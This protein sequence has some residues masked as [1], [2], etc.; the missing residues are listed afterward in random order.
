[1]T[2]KEHPAPG[3]TRRDFIGG[4]LVGAGAALLHAPAPARAKGLGAEWTGYGGVGDYRFSNGNTASVVESAHAIRDHLYEGAPRN[5]IDV[6]EVYDAVIVGGGFSG[7]AAL[8]EFQKR[9]PDAKCLLLENHPIFGGFAKP[10]EFD[11]DG[12]RITGPQ[13]SINFMLPN[14]SAG[15]ADDYW[16]ELGLP[17]QFQFAE[18]Q[19][20]EGSIVFPR[21][22]SAAMY[23]GEQT[24]SVGYYFQN[25]QTHG[26][27]TW[28]KDI[29]NGDLE[30]APLS[31]AMKRGLLAMRDARLQ[32]KDDAKANAWLDG[33]TFADLVTRVMGLSPE[34]LP[35]VAPVMGTSG[36]NPQ[37][38]A[39]AG[40][41]MSYVG[42]FSDGNTV[43]ERGKRWVSF[44]GG[45][46]TIYRHFVKAVFPDAIQGPRTFEAIANNSVDLSVLDREGARRRMRLGSTA[47]RVSHEGDPK[48]ADH[49]SVVYEKDGQLYRVRAKGAALCIGS[50]VAKHIVTDLPSDYGVA[51]NQFFHGPILMVNVALRNW[52]FLDKLGFSAARWFDGFGFFATIRRPMVI[53]DRTTPFHPD[54]P[55]VMTFYVPIQRNDLPLAAQGPA[56]R[57]LMYGTSYAAYE[58]QI[59]AQMQRLFSSGGFNAH[60]DIAGIVLNRWGH[61]LI[62]PPPGFFFGVDGK[63]GPRDVIRERFGRI[64]FGHSELGWGTWESATLEGK[65]AISQV[66]QVL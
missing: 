57:G 8:Y 35:Y 24:A 6:E 37:V 30:R 13:A 4:T 16:H 45:N 51:F 9:A 54:K 10:N 40:R 17:D 20:H 56:G 53:G 3:I 39:Y 11:V 47:M 61:A 1:M 43:A 52:R 7:M 18:R 25:S 32:Y 65:R 58:Q 46:A 50:W 64:S 36:M 49:V 26:K 15:H 38:S 59:V 33:I 62:S 5:I 31:D 41:E 66:L 21:A 63:P 29:W 60:R 55:I 34:V 14:A 27:G 19:D 2:D 23:F 28:V 44:P 12:Y 42:R 22:T 48:S